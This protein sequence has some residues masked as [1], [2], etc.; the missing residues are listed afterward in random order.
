MLEQRS[1]AA[2]DAPRRPA[3]AG[4]RPLTVLAL[5]ATFA[6]ML[7]IPTGASAR[8]L[9]VEIIVFDDP[10]G[11]D[12]HAEH[13]PADPGE[14][15]LDGA[16]EIVRSPGGEA[17]GAARAYRLVNRSAL[18]LNGVWRSLRRSAHYR[19]FLHVGWRLPGLSHGAARP[20]HVGPRLGD[21]GAG[22]AGPGGGERPTVQGTVKVSVARYLH[23]KLDLVYRRPGNGEAETPNAVPARFRLV[24]ERRM[25]YGEL[26]YID[27]PLFGVLMRIRPLR[28]TSRSAGQFP[29]TGISRTGIEPPPGSW[30]PLRGTGRLRSKEGAGFL[31]PT[32][33]SDRSLPSRSPT[34]IVQRTGGLTNHAHTVAFGA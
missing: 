31:A 11:E 21:R 4:A 2:A 17:G 27:H 7:A 3:S 22:G 18:A 12:L 29:P 19:P 6:A 16:V 23:V 26:H 10:S 25:R 32:H 33:G 13:W 28:T 8:S 30:R 5:A 34:S 24:S 20:V 14:P 9:T 15:S 1:T